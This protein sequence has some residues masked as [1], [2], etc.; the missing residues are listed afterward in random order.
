MDID[1]KIAKWESFLS[2]SHY[3]WKIRKA[4]EQCINQL[5]ACREEC[6]DWEVLALSFEDE[7]GE[8]VSEKELRKALMDKARSSVL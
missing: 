5:K 8:F 3:S 2:G 4:L 7:D 1:K 6:A